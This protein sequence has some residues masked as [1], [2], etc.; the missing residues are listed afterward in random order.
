ML[1]PPGHEAIQGEHAEAQHAYQF[2]P[3]QQRLQ[4]LE[5]LREAYLPAAS[6]GK[7]LFEISLRGLRALEKRV[8]PKERHHIPGPEPGRSDSAVE[9][10]NQRQP[11]HQPVNVAQL[12]RIAHNLPAQGRVDQHKDAHAQRVQEMLGRRA[13]WSAYR[14]AQRRDK[15]IVEM[16]ERVWQRVD[17][18]RGRW[19]H[20]KYIE[21][22]PA[23]PERRVQSDDQP[24]IDG[25]RAAHALQTLPVR[26]LRL[27]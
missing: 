14:K 8:Q 27:L 18:A 1:R 3:Q 16:A 2:R 17:G 12:L 11:A 13:N 21:N 20:F 6:D 22:G 26:L 9:Q 23:I 25:D 19:I 24:H 10:P 5:L 4:P 15:T 7:L